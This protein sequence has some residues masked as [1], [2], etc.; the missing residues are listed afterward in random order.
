MIFAIFAEGLA[1]TA[2]PFDEIMRRALTIK[3]AKP[4]KAKK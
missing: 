2:L 1:P 4:K 3:P